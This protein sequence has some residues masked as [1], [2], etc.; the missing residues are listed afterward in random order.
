MEVTL[1]PEIKTILITTFKNC[2]TLQT[3]V[4]CI[5]SENI[6]FYV[7]CSIVHLLVSKSH[8]ERSLKCFSA[9]HCAGGVT[10]IAE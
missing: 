7:M 1:Q 9:C 6:R 3:S 4:I 5:E 8:L 2:P 10:R